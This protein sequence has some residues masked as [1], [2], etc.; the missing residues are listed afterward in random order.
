MS[1]SKVGDIT[2][3]MNSVNV[4]I[5]D[6]DLKTGVVPKYVNMFEIATC[7]IKDL[8]FKKVYTLALQISFK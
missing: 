4:T 1:V 7:S 6:V 5:F 8:T 3:I 2:E